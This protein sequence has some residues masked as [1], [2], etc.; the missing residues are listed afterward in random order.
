MKI[1]LRFIKDFK[2]NFYIKFIKKEFEKN[3]ETKKAIEVN[4]ILFIITKM[5]LFKLIKVEFK[6]KDM[7][8]S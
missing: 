2:T 6:I 1:S 5:C 4:K 8:R 3:I 7:V